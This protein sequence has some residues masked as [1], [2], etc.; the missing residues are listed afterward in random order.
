[1]KFKKSEPQKPKIKK[2]L[3][4]KHRIT[5]IN[6]KELKGLKNLD[7]HISKNLVA[8]MGVNG[9]GKSTIL[10]ALACMYTPFENGENY[11]F[12]YF[13]TPNTDSNWK[14][15]KL[16]MTYYD[17]Y[18]KK[19]IVR[20][21]KKDFDR[22]APRYVHRPKRD[23]YFLG[24]TSCIPEIEIEKQTS[25]I[26]Y[27]TKDPR[28]DISKKIV[29]DAAY[30]LN[31]NYESLT[32]H[33]TKKK[34]LIGVCTGDNITYSSLSMGA[35]EQRIIKMLKL[36]YTVNQYSLI[37]IDEIDML[38]HVTAFKKLIVKFAEIAKKRNLQIFFTTHSL[39]INQFGKYVDIR[40]L[41]NLPE[42]TMVYDSI[43][44]EMI[45]D[46]SEYISKPLEIFVEDLLAETIIKCI[47]EGLNILSKIKVIKYGAVT[48]AFIMASSIVLKGEDYKNTLIVLDG[49]VYKTNEEKMAAIKKVLTGTE[50]QHV[51]KIVDAVSII[52]DLNLPTDISPEEF[53]YSLLIEMPEEKEIIKQA[54]KI[55]AVSNSH[56]WI[57]GLVESMG[58][59]KEYVLPNIIDTV[60]KNER[61]EDYI[62]TIHHWMLDK[63]RELNL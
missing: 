38:L 36:L 26:H 48:N 57:D 58:H 40:Y 32:S 13:F 31:K 45:Y 19:E 29:N 28:D 3:L 62:S 12:S 14:N 27:S 10:H 16:S 24:I 52:K 2:V 49:D 56:Q 5:N 22:W 15:S 20:E 37:L 18:A 1:M 55:N 35:G 33:K 17:E 11:K 34:D 46:L 51:K 23:I 39:E 50:E 44:Y 41:D 8:I 42:K 53:I 9:C 7:I 6:I 25:F 21:Y 63:K 43:T 61:W 59:V 4:P 54:K 47:A 60:K 30:I